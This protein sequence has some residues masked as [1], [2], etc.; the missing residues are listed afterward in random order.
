MRLIMSRLVMGLRTAGFTVEQQLDACINLGRAFGVDIDFLKRY[1][2][3]NVSTEAAAHP[4]FQRRWEPRFHLGERVLA[5]ANGEAVPGVVRAI[6]DPSELGV[7]GLDRPYR[8][9]VETAAGRISLPE[10]SVGPLP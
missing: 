7:P 2:V 8:Y 4:F 5:G 9:V 3:T 1:L 6:A 10:D